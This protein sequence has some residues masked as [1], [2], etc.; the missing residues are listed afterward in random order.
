MGVML[1]LTLLG[2]IAA[3]IANAI[4][5]GLEV[6]V[7]VLLGLFGFTLVAFVAFWIQRR[8]YRRDVAYGRVVEREPWSGG[9]LLPPG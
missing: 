7:F 6:T 2:L 1:G 9:D 3:I 5:G 4:V 8:N